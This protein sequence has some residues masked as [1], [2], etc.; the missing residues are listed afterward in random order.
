MITG[1]CHFRS[2]A[3]AE[4]YYIPYITDAPRRQ[5]N[6]A[7]SALVSY[8]LRR[9]EIHIGEPSLQPGESLLFNSKEGRY[10][11]QS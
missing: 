7:V 10:F 11:I 1:T 5:R 8:K 9:G 3:E 4:N 6:E 2:R